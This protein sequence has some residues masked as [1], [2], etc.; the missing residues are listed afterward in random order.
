MGE[1]EEN[2]EVAQRID[3][4]DVEQLMGQMKVLKLD[5]VVKGYCQN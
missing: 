4:K 5:S 2:L 1:R 3:D